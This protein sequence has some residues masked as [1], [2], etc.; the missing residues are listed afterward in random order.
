MPFID[1]GHKSQ[2]LD[3][4]YS[5]NFEISMV[6]VRKRDAEPEFDLLLDHQSTYEACSLFVDKSFF[7]VF[8][9]S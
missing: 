5:R 9:L 3:C 6:L 7:A 2:G 4:K 8:L 1:L